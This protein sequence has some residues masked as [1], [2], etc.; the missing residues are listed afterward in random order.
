VR[1]RRRETREVVRSTKEG[2]TNFFS[3]GVIDVDQ[4]IEVSIKGRGVHKVGPAGKQSRTKFTRVCY[5][6]DSGTSVVLCKSNFCFH[7]S[8][9]GALL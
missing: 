1:E 4:P 3:S 7:G 2:E 9:S 6:P 5:D 8:D